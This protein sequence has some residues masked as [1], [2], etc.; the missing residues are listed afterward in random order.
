MS[1]NVPIY[2]VLSETDL[3]DQRLSRFLLIRSHG[4]WPFF[5]TVFEVEEVVGWLLVNTHARLDLFLG[6]DSL[7]VEKSLLLDFGLVCFSNYDEL[8]D[9]LLF[10]IWRVAAVFVQSRS[11][12]EFKF[13]FVE[14]SISI[15]RLLEIL[16]FL[17]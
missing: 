3:L 9:A 16:D 14:V 11:E 1:L 10:G 7:V 2:F 8:V 12:F 4:S 6:R 15:D 17:I 5:I 13:L